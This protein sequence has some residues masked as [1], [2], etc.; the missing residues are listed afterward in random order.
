MHD[1]IFS[2]GLFQ[3][4]FKESIQT[5]LYEDWQLR[6]FAIWLKTPNGERELEKEMMHLVLRSIPSIRNFW[7]MGTTAAPFMAAMDES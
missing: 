4:T 6:V 7:S 5:R 3:D 1:L 2:P